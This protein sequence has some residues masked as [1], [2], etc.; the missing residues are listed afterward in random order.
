MSCRDKRKESYL[1]WIWKESMLKKNYL[2]ES[3]PQQV[4]LNNS[5]YSALYKRICYCTPL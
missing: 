5:K 4:L 1:M 3:K 2:K